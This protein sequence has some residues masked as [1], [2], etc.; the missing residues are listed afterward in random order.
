MAENIQE[1]IGEV[2]ALTS[3]N[4]NLINE[5]EMNQ[6]AEMAITEVKGI[7]RNPELEVFNVPEAERAAFWSCCLFCKIHMG[8]LDGV[9][10]S[11]GEINIRQMPIRDIT[12]VWYRQLD[13]YI[14]LLRSGDNTAA[15]TQVR[16]LDR[17]Y[18]R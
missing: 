17:Q 12:R 4:E 3:Y 5:V 9:D 1:L 7:T 13:Y 16:R 10:F 11:L 6:L 2:R 8:E 18:E 15:I 14:N